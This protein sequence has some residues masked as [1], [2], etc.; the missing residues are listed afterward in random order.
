MPRVR[1]ETAPAS[2]GLRGARPGFQI[3]R[4]AVLLDDSSPRCRADESRPECEATV[5]VDDPQLGSPAKRVNRFGPP[6]QLQQERSSQQVGKR[7]SRTC[8]DQSVDRLDGAGGAA[9]PDECE[10]EVALSVDVAGLRAR[11]VPVCERGLA[12]LAV[13][14]E[15]VAE[16]Q[17]GVDESWV[18]SYGIA[19]GAPRSLFPAPAPQRMPKQPVKPSGDPEV[20]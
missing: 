4:L 9:R 14:S 15:R 16:R 11:G 1:V 13:A 6:T 8:P 17:V 3:P 19:E 20:R 18:G 10:D 5:V 12:P 2:L 7:V